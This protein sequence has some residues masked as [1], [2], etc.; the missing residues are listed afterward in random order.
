MDFYKRMALVCKAIPEGRVATY[1]Q[2]ALLCGKPKNARQA[3]YGLSRNLAGE[4]IPAHRVVNAKGIL[5]G[6]AAFDTPDLQKLLLENEG[7]EVKKI[8]EGFQVDLKR[9]GWKNSMEDA[10]R[11]VETFEQSGI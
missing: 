8:P 5:S 2:I 1:G 9:F 4:D 7:V 11:M 6:A 10:V 3:G